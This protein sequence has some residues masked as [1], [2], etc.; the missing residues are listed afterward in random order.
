MNLFEGSNFNELKR[1][2]ARLDTEAALDAFIDKIS[3]DE[4]ISDVAYENLRHYAIDCYYKKEFERIEQQKASRVASESL[5]YPEDMWINTS[6]K[7]SVQGPGYVIKAWA[8][9]GQKKTGMPAFDSAKQGIVYQEF[10]DVLAALKT[11]KLSELGAYEITWI[12]SNEAE[13]K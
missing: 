3:E 6:L 8:E 2:A 11:D 9:P 5:T 12:K 7:E 1:E 10:D 13:D 4:S